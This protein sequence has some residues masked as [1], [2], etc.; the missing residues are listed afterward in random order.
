MLIACF[1]HS[2]RSIDG[3]SLPL[4]Q[5]LDENCDVLLAWGMNGEKL[6]PD[7]GFPVRIIIPGYIGGRSIKW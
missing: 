6:P 1:H 5:V 4:D 7:H 2:R 3:T